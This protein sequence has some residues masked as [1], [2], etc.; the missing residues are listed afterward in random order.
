[1]AKLIAVKERKLVVQRHDGYI[2]P[3]VRLS[4]PSFLLSSGHE[5]TGSVCTVATTLW[6]T[7]KAVE[8]G[9]DLLGDHLHGVTCLVI[10][11]VR[12]D[13]GVPVRV[14]RHDAEFASADFYPFSTTESVV[15][16]DCALR[17]AIFDMDCATDDP[18]VATLKAHLAT[19]ALK[20]KK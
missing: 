17:S 18:L 20:D 16:R 12:I 9:D 15:L 1:M 7:W 4:H 3:P 13:D 14:L 11:D 2:L 5:S 10:W 8:D 19:E 6:R